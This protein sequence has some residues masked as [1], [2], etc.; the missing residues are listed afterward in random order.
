MRI[1]TKSKSA[2]FAF[3]TVVDDR[4]FKIGQIKIVRLKPGG[5]FLKGPRKIF[6]TTGSRSNVATKA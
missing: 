5:N 3:G 6:F 2:S 1:T 4:A